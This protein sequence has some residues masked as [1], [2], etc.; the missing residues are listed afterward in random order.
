MKNKY[1]ALANHLAN[2]LDNKVGICQNIHKHTSDVELHNR[3]KL[4][5]QLVGKPHFSGDY[6]YPVAS[7]D[8][9]HRVAFYTT[10]CKEE[11]MYSNEDSYGISRNIILNKFITDLLVTSVDYEA[12]K[13]RKRIVLGLT[14]IV[15]ATVISYLI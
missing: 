11:G 12:R 13:F 14:A 8:G 1:E 2:N 3:F 10:L 15:V 5:A 9:E 6:A 7:P 4:S